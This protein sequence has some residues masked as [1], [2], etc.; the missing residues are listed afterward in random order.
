MK[1]IVCLIAMLVMITNVAMAEGKRSFTGLYAAIGHQH[2]EGNF[3]LSHEGS[4]FSFGEIL[5]VPLVGDITTYKIGYRFPLGQSNLR[6]GVNATLHDGTI[7]GSKTWESR[8]ATA[9]FAVASDLRLSLGAEVGMVLGKRE[10]LYVYAGAGMVVTN[11]TA[12]MSIDTQWGGWADQKE[13]GAIG[14]FYS[15]GL[16]YQVSD[17]L[18]VDF[19]VSQM[20]FDAGKAFGLGSMGEQHLEAELKQ[21]T[22]GF[23]LVYRF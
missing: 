4:K 17:K 6:L 18:A 10:R 15:L 2:S 14:A 9:T 5:D 7:G 3:T 8:Y 13:G 20:Q 22:V 19:S 1:K 16:E 12:Q 23:S 21:A 11:L